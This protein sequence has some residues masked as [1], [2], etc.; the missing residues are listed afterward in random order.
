MVLGDKGEAVGH[1]Q[2]LLIELGYSIANDELALQAYGPSTVSAVKTFQALKGLV[3]DGIA[4]THTLYSLE[5]PG[6]K[7]IV[8]GWY[9]QPSKAR[10]AVR[11]VVQ[12]A[13]D[14]IGI[15]EDPDGSNRGGG[16]DKFGG[17]GD[18]W[19][20]YFVSWC[21]GR[22]DGGSP[23][24]VLASAYKIHDWAVTNNRVLAETVP[25][26]GGDVFVIIRGNGHGHVG[27]V[28]DVLPDGR[29]VCIEGNA[30]NAV[31]GTLRKRPDVLCLVRPIL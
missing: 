5:H 10:P 8:S 25:P 21:Y 3:S 27:L 15:H 13:G 31:R 11:A 17:H 14:Q 16:V 4:G 24:G 29:L 28:G 19:C 6:G 23:F 1:V 18:P 30:G 22:A 26:E 2:Q 20:A 12:A 7:Y 9:C